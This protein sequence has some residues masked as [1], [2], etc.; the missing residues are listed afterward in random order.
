MILTSRAESATVYT[1][2]ELLSYVR[3]SFG[4][5]RLS[6]YLSLSEQ[7]SVRDDSK[8]HQGSDFVKRPGPRDSY[9]DNIFS[10]PPPPSPVAND[11][12]SFEPQEGEGQGEKAKW[13]SW[14]EES[15]K[16]DTFYLRLALNERF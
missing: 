15:G 8:H 5:I 13:I 3:W 11:T 2:Y 7:Q 6:R 14:W 10:S 4:S 9:A 12:D 1:V 16:L